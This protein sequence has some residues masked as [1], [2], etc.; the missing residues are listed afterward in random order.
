MRII[1]MLLVWRVRE[2][3]KLYPA[4]REGGEQ[5]EVNFQKFLNQ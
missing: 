4:G 1:R 2:V 3:C 5:N